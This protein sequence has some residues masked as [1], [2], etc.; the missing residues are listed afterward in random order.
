M[1]WYRGWN[2]SRLRCKTVVVHDHVNPVLMGWPVC[3]L[4][5]TLSQD[6]P[7]ALWSLLSAHGHFGCPQFVLMTHCLGP[8]APVPI[9]Q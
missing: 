9:G 1:I 2:F 3:V 4:V 8:L 7:N 6:V 5:V